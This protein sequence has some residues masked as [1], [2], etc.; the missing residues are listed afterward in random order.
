ML[1][2]KHQVV[3]FLC[4]DMWG[5][6]GRA[7]HPY[8]GHFDPRIAP[9][10]V[11]HGH[12]P[13]WLPPKGCLVS[14]QEPFHGRLQKAVSSRE[15]ELPH[16][17]RWDPAHPER[18]LLGPQ[19][20]KELQ[21]A[22]SDIIG[23]WRDTGTLKSGRTRLKKFEEVWQDAPVYVEVKAKRRS[24]RRGKPFTI[25]Y[26]GNAVECKNLNANPHAISSHEKA[27]PSTSVSSERCEYLPSTNVEQPTL[28]L[29]EVHDDEP[30]SPGAELDA[31][32]ALCE[33]RLQI[34]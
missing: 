27:N 15:W 6:A 24:T 33:F 9:N 29:E 34:N 31:F 14:C 32:H 19:S 17:R 13:V 26:D 11:S 8:K 12:R 4:M 22:V 30:L 18:P 25:D 1:E 2:F 20:F 21:M 16:K 23:S 7:H 5:R 28:N 3:K 10:F